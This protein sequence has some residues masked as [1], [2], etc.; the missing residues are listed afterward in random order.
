M[1]S[2]QPRIDEDLLDLVGDE[3]HKWRSDMEPCGFNGIDAFTA[4]VA[5][6]LSRQTAPRCQCCGYL[7]TQSEHQSCLRAAGAKE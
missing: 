7:V 4:G 2:K 1:S 6:A 5:W 3:Y